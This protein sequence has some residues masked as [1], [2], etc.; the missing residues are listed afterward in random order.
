MGKYFLDTE[1]YASLA[2]AVAAEGCVL[3]KNDNN[4][5]PLQKGEKVAV[6]GRIAHTYYKS[7]LGSGGLVNTR[8][9]VGILDALR[10]EKNI[11][12][13]ET[14]AKLYEDWIKEHPYDEGSG[15]GKV[16]WAQE[17]MPMSK[18]LLAAGADADAAIVV[19]GR[20]AGEDQDNTA[21]KGSYLLTDAE[22]ELI[23]KVSA[24]F[25]RTIVVLNVGN[26][27]D[28]KWVEE[29]HPAAVLYAWQGGQ[30]GGN[31]VVDI[32]MG[33]VNPSGK[34]PDTI[35]RDIAD[36]PSTANF[37]GEK[38][39]V[40]EED[41][42][43]GYRYFETFA[44]E[45]VL[46]PFGYGLSYTTFD[47]QAR[48]SENNE[49]EFTLEVAVTN[50]GKVAGKEAVQVYVKAPQGLLGK[51]ARVLVGFSKTKELAPGETQSL[52]LVIDKSTY[53]SYDDSGVT[54]YRSCYVLEDGE[55][56]IFVGTDVRS[57]VSVTS[58][59]ETF[60][61][62]EQ[63]EEA[64]AP[65]KSFRRMK[66]RSMEDGS[67]N[68]D[69][70]DA[71]LQKVHPYDR[72]KASL[73]AEIPYTGNRGYKLCDVYHNKVSM[74]EF[75]AQLGD[76]ELITLFR[77]EG[78]CSPKV[79]PGTASAFGGL[80][81][82]LKGYGIPA[83]C[84]A[85]GPSGIRMDCGTKA[86]SLPNGTLLG[87]TFNLELVRSL[88]EFTGLELRKNRI[89]TLL[90]PGL[91]LHRSPLN[92]RNFEYISE[93]PLLTGKMGAVQLEGMNLSGTTGTIKHFST[94]NQEAHRR[95]VNAVVSERALREIYLKCF[96]IAVKEGKC[97]SVMT[98]YG[99]INGIWN[100]GNYDLNTTVLRKEW[101][102]EGIVMTDWW[103]G[104]NTEGE[105]CDMKNRAVMVLAQ[106][107]LFM[108][109]GDASNMSQDNVKEALESGVITRGELQRNAG[110][111]LNFLLRSPA[112]LYE[113]DAI[114]EEELAD[115]KSL[116]EDEVF[117]EDIVYYVQDENSGE[118]LIP[119]DKWDTK[120]GSQALFGIN[121]VKAGLYD[122]SI[123][124]KSELGELAQLPLSVYLDN[125]LKTTIS[126]RGSEGAT[127]TETRD[128]GMIFGNNHYIKLYFGASG[129]E[130]E[131]V[132]VSL[133]EEIKMPF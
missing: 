131:S 23:A 3:L 44:K 92:G 57:A 108:V 95:D 21:E 115:R 74:Q 8:Y 96:E 52:R 132:K 124:M 26:I 128:M 130:V 29:L 16:P 19:I 72:R 122:I 103:A 6:F 119:A 68:V 40:Y 46:Y 14:V 1:K 41:I 47:V 88:Y 22:Y 76:D 60:T 84:C 127:L 110:N 4:A 38:E 113:I 94:N 56:E 71:P 49:K 36:Y 50:T 91:N 98:S 104:A 83:G 45:R 64:L 102:F 66:P 35:A 78:M 17:E 85:D 33:R 5:L 7:G 58:L 116:D 87:A 9:V 81:E 61:V 69:Y 126:V 59:R 111:I 27:I 99:P 105:E 51:P 89:D 31:G 90:G 118:I 13:N 39:N 125:V 109:T 55:Y 133:R 48:L 82:S 117:A 100:A 67:F 25:D 30:E 54:G 75:I 2:R 86:F 34:L 43:V 65:V 37:G 73:P 112:M 10:E 20:T 42:Y 129:L 77:G 79:T 121:L 123:V 63:L 114:S 97:R 18:E 107:D 120:K 15:W 32:L 11:K 70:E 53:A 93:D 24:Q 101:G 12:L 62:I 80:S 28:M 106:N